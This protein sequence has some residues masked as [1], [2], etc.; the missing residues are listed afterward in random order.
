MNEQIPQSLSHLYDKY[1]DRVE[2]DFRLK[3]TLREGAQ[4]A[5][6]IKMNEFIK[7][8]SIRTKEISK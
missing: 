2:E 4:A 1:A 7:S 3:K 6:D 8:W 5:K